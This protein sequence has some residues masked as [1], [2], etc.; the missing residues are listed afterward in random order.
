MA[1]NKSTS[2][3]QTR[4]V[5]AISR[6][7]DKVPQKSSSA[8]VSSTPK[9]STSNTKTLKVVLI[10]VG[11]LVLLGVIGSIIVGFATKSIFEGGVKGLTGNNTKVDSKNGQ[12]TITSKDGKSTVSTSQKL[13]AG[14]P[15]DV[16]VYQPSTI[17]FSA[18]LTKNSYNV[19]LS[20]NDATDKVKAYYEKELKAEGWQLKPN[21]QI[22]FGSV[23]T[24]SYTKDK[25]ELTVVVTGD[26]DA[27]KSTA[28]SL[29]VKTAE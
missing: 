7:A 25:A 22:S 10:V 2:T 14:F 19:T 28:V 1:D 6:P 29:S 8:G 26:S 12:V 20:T 9:K 3:K 13:P 16:P 18:S 27:S 24:S 4:P 21:T 5:E 15:S 11:A 17:R 23:T